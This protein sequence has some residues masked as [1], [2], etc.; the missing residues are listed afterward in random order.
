VHAPARGGLIL[1][2]AEFY[3]LASEAVRVRLAAPPR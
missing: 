3:I 1:D 2:P